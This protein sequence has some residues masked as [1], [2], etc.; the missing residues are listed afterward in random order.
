MG[1]QYV[2]LL[3]IVA[4]VFVV[5]AVGYAIRKLG[6]LSAEADRSLIRT[7]V[8][9]LAPSLALDTIIG[10]EALRS[11]A[12]WLIPPLAGVGTVALGILVARIFSKGLP[13]TNPRVRKT[14]VF[15]TSVQNYAYIPL[16]LCLVLFGKE[17]VG[18]LFALVLGVELSF[19]SI[20][21][22]QLT[23][24]TEARS[25]RQTINPQVVAIPSAMLLNAI[26]AEHWIP[27]A[28]DSTF[29]LLGVC[30]VPL[31]LLMSGALVAD[32]INF[33]ALKK[34]SRTILL[35]TVARVVTLPVLILAITAL[36]PFDPN[37]KAILVLQ[38]AMPA[39]IFPIVVTKVHDGDVPTALQVVLGTSLIGLFAIP[40]WI[41]FGLHWVRGY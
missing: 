8:T 17:T 19:W 32:H 23:R 6:I 34:G 33:S 40:L 27:A 7:T 4:P 5:M 11:P 30:A 22:W 31:G 13:G 3:Q 28:I 39:A 37:L 21:L 36:V 15:T 38:A 35:A 2:S 1:A 24:G 9:V 18:V 20:A 41:G 29:H 25:W 14:F 16:P 12:N 26:G 10:N